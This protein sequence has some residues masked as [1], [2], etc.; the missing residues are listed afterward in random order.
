MTCLRRPSL[1]RS[2]RGF[3]LVELLVGALV[4]ALIAAATT[5]ALS[6]MVRARSTSLARQQAWS[7]AESATARIARDVIGVVRD[8]ELYFTRVAI[9]D[10]PAGGTDEL[11]L[12]CRSMRRVRGFPESPEGPDFEVQ[13]RV[14]DASSGLALW[15]RVDP[16]LDEYPDAGGVAT[17]IVP[18]VFSLSVE[19]SDGTDWLSTWD[20]D[21]D[22]IPYGLRIIVTAR[23]DGGRTIATARRVIALDR[24]PPPLQVLDEGAATEGTGSSGASPQSGG[25]R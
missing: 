18:G 3:T 21:Y 25:A 19:A 16:A 4:T 1:Q 20:S 14:G 8:E 24:V 10:G 12:L 9:A 17:A 5:A 6:Q 15:R 2:R 22:G 7:R 11:L 23:D 13:Y